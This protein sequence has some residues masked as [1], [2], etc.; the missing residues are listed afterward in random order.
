MLYSAI[1]FGTLDI[2]KKQTKANANNIALPTNTPINVWPIIKPTIASEIL[3]SKAEKYGSFFIKYNLYD[4]ANIRSL[5]IKK[6]I[7]APWTRSP[8]REANYILATISDAGA[9]ANYF[10]LVKRLVINTRL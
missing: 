2:N 1:P 6:S 3:N 7:N 4:R 8:R 5:I 9:K 10:G